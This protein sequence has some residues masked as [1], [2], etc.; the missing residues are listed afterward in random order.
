MWETRKAVPFVSSPWLVLPRRWVLSPRTSPRL[1]I[2]TP[3]N[4]RR[5]GG[6]FVE[7]ATAAPKWEVEQTANANSNSNSNRRRVGFENRA[8]QQTE[9]VVVVVAAKTSCFGQGGT[10]HRRSAAAAYRTAGGGRRPRRRR[11]RSR[12]P[13]LSRTP[14]RLPFLLRRRRPP[15]S[16]VP[17]PRLPC[18]RYRVRATRFANW[19]K[20]THG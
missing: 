12:R 10:R 15:L 14:S 5:S 7:T 9:V 8:E 17:T 2:C 20:Q 6:R 13:R 1:W 4:P 18:Q 11:R 16:R 19:T 3:R